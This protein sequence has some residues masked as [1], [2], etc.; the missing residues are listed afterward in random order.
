[1]G[2]FEIFKAIFKSRLI[3]ALTAIV[4]IAYYFLIQYV[5][6]LNAPGGFIF[7]TTPAIMFYLL[8][9]SASVLLIISAYSIR[10]SLL[11]MESEFEGAASIISTVLGGVIAGCNCSVPII[12]SI[13][14]LFALNAATVSDVVAFVGNYQLEIFALL[15]LFNIAVSY[16]HLERL[17]ATCT[18]KKGRL[19]R[20]R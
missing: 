1:M 14:Y 9:I 2:V 15:I 4:A 12:S 7:V 10:L 18:I 6:A 3:I 11:T 17:S 19:Q 20:K 8:A 16:H 5:I 13:L